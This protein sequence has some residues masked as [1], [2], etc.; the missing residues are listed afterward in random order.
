VV[1]FLN[2]CETVDFSGRDL[3][4]VVS[5]DAETLLEEWDRK[6]ALYGRENVR[7]NYLWGNWDISASSNEDTCWETKECG[8]SSWQGR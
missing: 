4:F 6:K 2:S 1:N 3:L 5:L 7:N 8:F